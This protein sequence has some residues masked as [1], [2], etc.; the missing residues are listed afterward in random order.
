MQDS[1][2]LMKIELQGSGGR[3]VRGVDV[4]SEAEWCQLLN[5]VECCASRTM[6]GNFKRT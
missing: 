3:A 5:P 4:G 6:P 2:K 1:L